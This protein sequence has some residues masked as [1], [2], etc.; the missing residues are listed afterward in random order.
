MERRFPALVVACWFG[1]LPPECL[2]IVLV[3][4]GSCL[5]LC[6]EGSGLFLCPWG[7]DDCSS[8]GARLRN[9]IVGFLPD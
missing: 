5:V 6:F 9:Y 1:H 8:C 2:R 3:W 4:V 7:P